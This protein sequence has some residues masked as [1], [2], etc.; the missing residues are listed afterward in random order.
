MMMHFGIKTC[1]LLALMSPR[2]LA[3]SKDVLPTFL[4]LGLSLDTPMYG[5][6]GK[7]CYHECTMKKGLKSWKRL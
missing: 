3:R 7:N 5:E 4:P 6:G 1:L 2:V